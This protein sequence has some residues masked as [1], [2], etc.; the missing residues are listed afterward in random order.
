MDRWSGTCFLALKQALLHATNLGFPVPGLPCNLD[1]DA[2]DVAVGAVLS[3]VVDGVK[4]PI[5]FYSQTSLSSQSLA[6]V[7]TT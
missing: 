1:T 4:R 6:L 7:V 3:Q 2:S 5:A